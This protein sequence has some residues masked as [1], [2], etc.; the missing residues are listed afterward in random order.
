[1]SLLKFKFKIFYDKIGVLE[2]PTYD[3]RLFLCNKIALLSIY[4]Y[5]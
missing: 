4:F 1:M 5:N 2:I 3:A